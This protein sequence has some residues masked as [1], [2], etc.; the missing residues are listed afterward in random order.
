MKFLLDTNACVVH[1]RGTSAAVTTRL[2]NAGEVALCSV[3]KA[4]LAYG[5][6]RSANPD[7]NRAQLHRFVTPFLSLPFDDS[8]AA[9]YGRLRTYLESKGTPIGPNDLM[10]A[11]IALSHGLTL[12]TTTLPNS[13]V[14]P[15][16]RSKTGRLLRD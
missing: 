1:L 6:E 3:V 16:C 9:E 12:I 13:V 15:A 2:T 7:E 14:F 5:A 10:I 8:A 4:E 11:S